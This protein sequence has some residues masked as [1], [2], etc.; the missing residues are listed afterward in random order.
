MRRLTLLVLLAAMT[1]PAGAATK[2]TVVQL[3]QTVAAAHGAPDA[4][5]AEQLS[6]LELTERLSASRFVRL[7]A[8]LPGEKALQA[9][10]VLADAA[11]FL[12]LPAAEIPSTAAPDL[13]AQRQMMSLVVSYTT[14]SI[15][16]LPNFFATRET[17]RF[18]DRPQGYYGYMPLHFIAKSSKSVVYREGQEMID[19]ASGKSGRSGD[20]EQGLVSWGEFGPILSTVLLDAAQS[21][22]AWSHWEQGAS[23]PVAVFGYS[24]PDPKSHY[25]VQFC[26]VGG[27]T[28]GIPI[29]SHDG[30]QEMES[31]GEAPRVV[32]EKAG[33]HGEIAIDPA[34]GTILRMTLD[35]ELPLSETLTRAAVMVEYGSVEIGGKSFICPRHSVALSLMRFAHATAGAHSILDHD[36]LKTFLNDVAFEQYHRLGA[37][38][39]I[40]SGDSGDLAGNSPAAPPDASM[41]QPA[42]AAMAGPPQSVENGTPAPP[43]Q[44]APS[45]VPA[46]APAP[47]VAQTTSS[48]APAPEA[49]Q[50]ELQHVPLIK[51][52][53]RTVVVDVVVTN[54]RQEPVM[55]LDK[56]FFAVLEDGMPQ[57]INYFEE[58]TATPAPLSEAPKLA[59]NLYTN[60]PAT[61]VVDS[62]NVVLIDKLNTPLQDQV[63][64]HQQ[65]LDFLQKMKPGTKIA[66]FVMGSRMRLLHGFTSDSA[67]LQAAL[68][69]PKNGDIPEK[70]DASRS[71]QD[72]ADD[73][74]QAD[75]HAIMMGGS[76]G[77]FGTGYSRSRGS[78]AAG[79]ASIAGNQ[80]GER[81]SMTLTGLEFLA[82]YL[83]G[84][85]GRKNL[86]W[87]SSAFPV[88]VFP[89]ARELKGSLG[90]QS[91][92]PGAKEASN[93]L[94]LSDVAVYPVNAEGMQMDNA[95]EASGYDQKSIGTLYQQS[96]QRAIANE[97]VNKLA[98]DTGGK[99][100]TNTN[101]LAGALSHA[102]DDGAHYYTLA[103]TPAN[104][105]MDGGYR[106]I[107]V[108]L[109][110]GSYD[111]AYRRGYYADDHAA[112]EPQ[113]D[114]N[115]LQPLLV[116]G[117]PASTQIVFSAR[118]VPA[119]QQPAPG[120]KPAGGNTKLVGPLTRYRV[121]FN[122]R[123]SDIELI[124]AASGKHSGKIQVELL[125]Y[126]G[127]GAALN[128][129]GG[130]MAIQ[131]SAEQF[132][133]VQRTGIPAHLEIDLP[134]AALF[135]EAGVFDWT[136]RKAGTLEI[137]LHLSAAQQSK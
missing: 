37:E 67:Q 121:D 48:F 102:I 130:T 132:E 88:A 71:R 115:P 114:S 86:I 65:I 73:Q 27:N 59:T 35:S 109:T 40:L 41:L 97:A 44:P 11:E 57:K 70:T 99:A 92:D 82:R 100:F 15:H 17:T 22:L 36:P 137:P 58:H 80:A 46:V 85:Q 118:V 25:W 23:G 124:D 24:V 49:A 131:L 117:A 123:P 55:A 12:N 107:Q 45:T 56:Q 77:R 50:V 116:R 126:D 105:K 33:Y 51:A 5:L 106:R 133:S 91:F 2:V 69:D 30:S 14:R 122:L 134:S 120:D 54:S 110:Q 47:P 61:P 72:D 19:M 119:A 43:T 63:H 52:S 32:R 3:E 8:D 60:L 34:T 83:A 18:E 42:S 4:R 90:S 28:G 29:V 104:S 87:F 79:Q 10:T 78:L 125:A 108:R 84:I 68:N 1:V 7:K 13:A 53:A 128:W 6:G 113:A 26:C 103:Y 98:N 75:M 20:T 66:I 129:A 93:L 136:A 62:V 74:D 38:S 112:P 94:T 96:D 127:N 76:Q 111:L 89:S 95:T 101:D 16:E 21:K 9:L 31:T 64:V 81:V 39:R 135:L